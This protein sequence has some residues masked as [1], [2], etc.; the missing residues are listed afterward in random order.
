VAFSREKVEDE[1]MTR[2]RLS[3]LIWAVF[4]NAGITFLAILFLY[5]FTFLSYMMTN[6]FA[7]LLLFI[8]R[9]HWLLYKSKHSSDEE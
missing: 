3:A 4:V 5:S 7:V 8:I 6:L 9:Y 2:L 1:Y